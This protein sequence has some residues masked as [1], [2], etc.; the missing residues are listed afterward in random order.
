MLTKFNPIIFLFA[1]LSAFLLTSRN[2]LNANHIDTNLLIISN[3]IL[4]GISY[5]TLM[6][7]KKS[8]T[9]QNPNVF[10]RMVMGSMLTKMIVCVIAV[11]VYANYVGNNLN[12]GGIFISL[13]M[14]LV[15]LFTEVAY[16]L[17]LNKKSN[18]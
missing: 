16:I 5:F 12:K 2:F 9:H 8:M 17:K 1:L 4:F 14:Y 13:F 10:F 18:G 3:I 6:L 15:Y 7:Q 11:I